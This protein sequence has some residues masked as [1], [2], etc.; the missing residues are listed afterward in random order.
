MG[1]GQ[2]GQW[3]CV[4]QH[5]VEIKN[6]SSLVVILGGCMVVSMYGVAATNCV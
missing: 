3:I 2:G 5:L 6:K 4:M 1:L